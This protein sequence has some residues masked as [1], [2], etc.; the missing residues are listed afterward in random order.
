MRFLKSSVLAMAAGAL[1]LSISAQRETAADKP[2]MEGVQNGQMRSG[3]IMERGRKMRMREMMRSCPNKMQSLM[4]SMRQSNDAVKRDMEAAK[5][6]ND[7]AKMRA[8]LEEAEKSLNSA[9]N[10]MN[11]RANMMDMMQGRQGMC[12]MMSGKVMNQNSTSSPDER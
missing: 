10:H 8:A 11:G 12:G 3:E 7:P 2:Q 9:N 6:S 1:A 5:E 4:Q